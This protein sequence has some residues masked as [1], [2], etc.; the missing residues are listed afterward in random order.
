MTHEDLLEYLN[1]FKDEQ[2]EVVYKSILDSNILE[3]AFLTPEGK[4][5]LNQAIDVITSNVISIITK[6]ADKD[7]KTS[8]P[9]VYPHC[10]EINLA[11]K[12]L[13]GWSKILDG[14]KVHKTKIK[15]KSNG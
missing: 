10:M 11:Y 8:S 1:G 4:L 7:P 5:I 12:M 13:V 2:R 15:E 3:K 9:A 14:G 6:C